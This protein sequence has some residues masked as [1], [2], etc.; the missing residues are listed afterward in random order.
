M[1]GSSEEIT[2]PAWE[3]YD[4][5]KDPMENHNAYNDPVYAEIIKVMKLELQKQREVAGDTD[6]RYPV[7]KEIFKKYW[8]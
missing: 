2:E 4:L 3:F 8:N 7:M 5:E 6:V 1:T